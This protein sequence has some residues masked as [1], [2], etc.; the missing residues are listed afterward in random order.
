M[1]KYNYNVEEMDQGA[2]TSV[3]DLANAF[4]R[5]LLKVV[6]AWAMHFGYLEHI[7]RVLSGYFQLQRTVF[8]EG[9]VSDPLQTIAVIFEV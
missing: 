4:E 7:L 8:F 2:V 6:W 5:L 1:E 3:V 9:C